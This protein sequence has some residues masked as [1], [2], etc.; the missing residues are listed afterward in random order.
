MCSIFKIFLSIDLNWRL[1]NAIKISILSDMKSV[2]EAVNEG[3]RDRGEYLV[4]LKYIH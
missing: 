3:L 4:L 2:F 1:L